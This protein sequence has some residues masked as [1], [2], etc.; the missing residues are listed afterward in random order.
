MTENGASLR[1][2]RAGAR[3]E[4]SDTVKKA[5]LGKP[6]NANVARLQRL[7]GSE[8]MLT[9]VMIA[10]LYWSDADSGRLDGEKFRL[11]GVDAAETYRPDCEAERVTGFLA[12]EWVLTFTDGKDV[13]IS[14]RYG[15]DRYGREV[16]DLTAN[17]V[18]VATAG[19]EAGFLPAWDYDGG[20]AKPVWCD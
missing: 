10:A 8:S 14:K 3:G 11:H 13:Q 20:E 1:D 12:K 19:I 4:F 6:W 5:F 7:N 18:D 17:G 16:V 2:T 15:A 9:L